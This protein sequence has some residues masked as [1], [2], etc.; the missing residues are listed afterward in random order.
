M[1]YVRSYSICGVTSFFFEKKS[2][3]TL[4]EKCNIF[5]FFTFIKRCTYHKRRNN[6][7]DNTFSK[8]N[9]FKQMF[10]ISKGEG[11]ERRQVK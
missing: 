2:I 9:I 6:R 8:L 4:S 11:N 1:N 7:T 3:F 10:N 5:N